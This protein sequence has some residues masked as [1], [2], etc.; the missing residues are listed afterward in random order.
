[1]A[2]EES[3]LRATNSASVYRFKRGGDRRHD[4]RSYTE[5]KC[6]IE[7]LEEMQWFVV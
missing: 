5:S 1:M 4:N 6:S 7:K 3:R 2:K